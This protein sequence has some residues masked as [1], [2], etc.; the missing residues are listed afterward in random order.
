MSDD[1][2][3]VVLGGILGRDG[4]PIMFIK[5][6]RGKHVIAQDYKD[7]LKTFFEREGFLVKL[8]HGYY[9]KKEDE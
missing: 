8:Q 9:D 1:K 7:K 5:Y 4:C 2:L 6:P 3:E